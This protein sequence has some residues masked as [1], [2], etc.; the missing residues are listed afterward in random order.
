M[1]L[2]IWA[3]LKFIIENKIEFYGLGLQCQRKFLLF[4]F[5]LVI[6]ESWGSACG[7]FS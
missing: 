4:R 3:F 1:V 6:F 7:L 5:L 2:I